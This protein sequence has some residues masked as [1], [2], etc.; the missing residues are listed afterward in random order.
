MDLCIQ[1]TCGHACP[2]LY[3]LKFLGS[4]LPRHRQPWLLSTAAAYLCL[5]PGLEGF[6]SLPQQEEA[7]VS[8]P[9][10]SPRT[11]GLLLGPA[12]GGGGGGERCSCPPEVLLG[13][14]FTGDKGLG[15]GRRFRPVRRS[16]AALSDTSPVLSIF[17]PGSMRTVMNERALP[18]SLGL[19]GMLSWHAS[20]HSASESSLKC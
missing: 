10:P 7:F 18:L 1:P 19:P 3:Q 8:V 14:C 15:S 16:E 11:V 2:A 13:L 5:G 9:P 6:I 12:G 20:P 17:L 4:S